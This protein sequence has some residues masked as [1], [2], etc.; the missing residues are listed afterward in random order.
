LTPVSLEFYVDNPPATERKARVRVRQLSLDFFPDVY[1]EID[2]EAVCRKY[3]CTPFFCG[4]DISFYWVQ[5]LVLSP[6][7]QKKGQYKRVGYFTVDCRAVPVAPSG[8]E[9]AIIG[10]GDEAEKAEM[11]EDLYEVYDEKDDRY[12]FTII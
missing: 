3:Y 9:Q 11:T 7:G 8:F 4:T 5:G 1:E 10:R 12:T 6:S 2:E